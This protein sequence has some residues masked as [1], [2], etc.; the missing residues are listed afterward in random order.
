MTLIN[1]KM[2]ILICIIISISII[3]YG[4]IRC[5]LKFNDP[6]LKPI[7]INNKQLFDL[8][9]WSITH[10]IF[11]LILGYYFNNHI[12]FIIFMGTLWEVIEIIFGKI[13]YTLPALE[14]C[15]VKNKNS[16]WWYGRMSDIYINIIG[17]FCGYFLKTVFLK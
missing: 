7:T 2:I 4:Q 14:S 12:I 1:Y 6:L 11:F 5:K 13:S 15:H 3:I 8:D 16:D 17:V 9:G 10:F